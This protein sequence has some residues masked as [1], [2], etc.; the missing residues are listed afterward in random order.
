ML[1]KIVTFPSNI[2]KYFWGDNL[3]EL[4]WP[5]HKKYIIQTLLDKGDKSALKW[6]FAQTSKQK[7]KSYLPQL[8]LNKKSANFWS[9]YL[10]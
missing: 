9:T 2:K 5:K 4:S 6:L 10:S 8:K 1:K 7:V 3:Q